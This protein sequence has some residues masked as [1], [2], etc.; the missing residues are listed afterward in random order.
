MIDDALFS[1]LSNSAAISVLLI[2]KITP[3]VVPQNSLYPCITYSTNLDQE[4]RTFDGQGTFGRVSVE[5]D[6]W[7]DD[8]DGAIVLAKAISDTL[9][10]YRGTV[11]GVDIDSIYIDSVITVYEAEAEKYRRTQ[12]LTVI[13]Q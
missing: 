11:S 13:V 12:V 4:D 7:A 9:K 6:A 1:L 5:V 3:I 10:N 8:Y 2:G